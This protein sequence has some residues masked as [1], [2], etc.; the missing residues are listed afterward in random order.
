LCDV[1]DQSMTALT[2]TTESLLIVRLKLKSLL[3]DEEWE[4]AAAVGMS[5]LRAAAA[6]P[7]SESN[8]EE[9]TQIATA[10]ADLGLL[11]D[12]DVVSRFLCGA[13]SCVHLAQPLLREAT[14]ALKRLKGHDV[15]AWSRGILNGGA[16]KLETIDAMLQLLDTA[17]SHVVVSHPAFQST[18][19]RELCSPDEARRAGALQ[20]IGTAVLTTPA[21]A[22]PLLPVLVRAVFVETAALKQAALANV[23]DAAFALARLPPP[24]AEGSDE[25]HLFGSLMQWLPQ[26]LSAPLKGL[27]TLAALGLAKLVLHR[28]E[29]SLLC[30]CTDPEHLIAQLGRRYTA[31]DQPGTD[32]AASTHVPDPMPILLAFF[33]EL[34]ARRQDDLGNTVAP[35]LR[36]RPRTRGRCAT[37]P[38]LAATGCS[39]PRYHKQPHQVRSLLVTLSPCENQVSWMVLD[40]LE[41][42]RRLHEIDAETHRCAKFL[43]ASVDSDNSDV[44]T[45]AICMNVENELSLTLSPAEVAAW[46]GKTAEAHA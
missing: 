33:E 45:A 29:A 44:V 12:A 18:I 16:A 2:A 1:I 8:N 6:A 30:A 25:Q 28:K 32:L 3:Q 24:T 34:K 40:A 13:H 5:G 22:V 38:Q 26:M 17:T 41:G 19:Q 46:L 21:L 9:T 35:A 31:C 39:P 23:L 11:V 4:E 27:Q 42:K 37:H 7:P 15:E 36:S 20:V 14:V 10:L 43:F